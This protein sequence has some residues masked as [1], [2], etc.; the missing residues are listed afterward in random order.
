MKMSRPLNNHT[1]WVSNNGV[2]KR[3]INAPFYFK[4]VDFNVPQPQALRQGLLQEV[5]LRDAEKHGPGFHIHWGRKFVD[6]RYQ[7]D[8]KLLEVTL[9]DVETGKIYVV[10]AKYVIG[11]DGA[12]SAV[13]AWAGKFD[14]H[15]EEH[16]T[17]DVYWVQD[18][19]GIRSNFPDLE[20]FSYVIYLDY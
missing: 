7:A 11:A 17:P 19:V 20:R 15:M 12:K 6:M 4:S 13:R 2:V 9:Q 16:S 3:T 18:V 10:L 5:L 14:I 8:G 1:F